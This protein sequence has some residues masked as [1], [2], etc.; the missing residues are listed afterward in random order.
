MD[1]GPITPTAKAEA[2]SSQYHHNQ[3]FRSQK[4]HE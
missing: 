4:N 2:V 3:Y 1:D